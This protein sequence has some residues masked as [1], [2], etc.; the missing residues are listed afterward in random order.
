MEF[1][2]RIDTNLPFFYHTSSHHR[3]SEG[4]LPSFD[5][6]RASTERHSDRVP[7]REQPAAF[8]PG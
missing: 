5:E 7:Q 4:E 8:V 6:P 1:H 2:K 3:F